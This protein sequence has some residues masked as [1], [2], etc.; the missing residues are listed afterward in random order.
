MG[1]KVHPIGFRLGT[2]E[3]W[4]SRWFSDKDYKETLKSDLAIRKFLTAR[5]KDAALSRVE[6]ER[7][8][9]K[10]KVIIFTARPGIVIGK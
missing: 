7:A 2:P 5:L 3:N 1:Q 4:R 9:D 10:V 8:G 6:I